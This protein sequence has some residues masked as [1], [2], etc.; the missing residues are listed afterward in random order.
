MAVERL[1]VI[2]PGRAQPALADVSFSV[3]EG[4]LVSLV[5]PSGSGK[6]TLLRCVAGL[7]PPSA[8]AVRLAGRVIDDVP[9]D[10][11]MV[12]QDYGRSLFPWLSVHHNVELPLRRLRLPA[13]E[14]RDRVTAALSEVGLADAA[15]QYPW[16]LSGGMQQRVA[17]AR[18]IA[19]RARLLLMDE[20]FASVDA[21]TRAD[22]QDTALEVWRAHGSTI[23]FVTHDIDEAIYLADR[24][25]VLSPP[26][27][28]VRAAIAVDLP[29]PRDQIET[30]GLPRFAELRTEVARLIR[31][32]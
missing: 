24:V 20:P 10:L 27:G 2:Y 12:F 25:I 19:Y 14:R 15:R 18:A 32:A 22:L 29:R 8:G 5:G 4:E 7:R 1:T 30:R 26:P 13:A 23:L 3:R 11:A 16:Q 17:I 28:T 21:Q 9:P 6:T 31:R